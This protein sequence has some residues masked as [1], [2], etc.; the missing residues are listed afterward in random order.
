[1]VGDVVATLYITIFIRFISNDCSILIWVG[2]GL[3]CAAIIS[4]YFIV[5]SPEW[6][7]SIGDKQGAMKALYTVAKINGVKDF[8]IHDLKAAKFETIDPEK[9]AANGDD[10]PQFGNKDTEIEAEVTEGKKLLSNTEPSERVV[11]PEE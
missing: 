10:A 7:M 2:L 11:A 5:E 3:N 9:K 6:L 8:E 1:M 4:G